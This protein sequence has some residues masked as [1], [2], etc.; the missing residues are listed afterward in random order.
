MSEYQIIASVVIVFNI[1]HDIFIPL[2]NGEKP[3]KLCYFYFILL[4][5]VLFF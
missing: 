1:M 5:L 4:V 3:E 2:K